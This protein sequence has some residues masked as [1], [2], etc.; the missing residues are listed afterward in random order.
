[1]VS[2]IRLSN[3][4]S[5]DFLIM[6]I[7]YYYKHSLMRVFNLIIMKLIRDLVIDRCHES[8]LLSL[9]TSSSLVAISASNSSDYE[10]NT[11]KTLPKMSLILSSEPIQVVK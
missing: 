1:M 7:F 4:A 5:I 9:E 2:E 10:Q 6:I 8:G 3:H 11:A